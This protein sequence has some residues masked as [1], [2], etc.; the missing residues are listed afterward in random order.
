METEVGFATYEDFCT[1]K[2]ALEE[3]GYQEIPRWRRRLEIGTRVRHA[4][5]QFPAA[6]DHGTAVVLAIM[7]KFDSWEAAYSTAD[8]EVIVI[9]DKPITA[10]SSLV[11]T[12]ASYQTY[13]VL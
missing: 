3:S 9:R 6:Y 13:E 11:T 8:V 4:G 12:W 2:S 5:E 10:S 7:R 1:L